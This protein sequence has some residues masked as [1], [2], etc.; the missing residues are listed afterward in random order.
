MCCACT[1]G[2]SEAAGEDAANISPATRAAQLTEVC[3]AVYAAE[4]V[5]IHLPLT[6]DH[7]LIVVLRAIL[8]PQVG[9]AGGASQVS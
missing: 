4:G 1:G 8:L 6:A 7:P 3:G 9:G 2:D 5:S